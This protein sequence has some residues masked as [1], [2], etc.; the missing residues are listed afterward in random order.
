[1]LAY[2]IIRCSLMSNASRQVRREKN[3]NHGASIRHSKK[4]KTKKTLH[5]RQ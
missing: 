1:M 2:F 3:I 4:K 5:S